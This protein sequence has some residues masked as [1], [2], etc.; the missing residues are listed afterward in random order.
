VA[1]HADYDTDSPLKRRLAIVQRHIVEFLAS[2]DATP[3]RVVSMCA[4]EARDLLGALAKVER[5]DICGRLVELDPGNAAVAR[6]RCD[7]LGLTGLE[8][9]VGDAGRA[10]AYADAVPADLVLACGVFGNISDADVERT[11]GALPAFC[12]PG[13]TVIWTRHRR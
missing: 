2:F 7:D 10:Q 13:A 9:L 12:A 6:G 4:G 8:V 11:V 1:W 5:R 3:V